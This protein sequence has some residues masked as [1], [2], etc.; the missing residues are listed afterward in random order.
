[1]VDLEL[2]SKRIVHQMS[3]EL[4]KTDVNDDFHTVLL[5]LDMPNSDRKAGFNGYLK[6]QNEIKES[7]KNYIN[8][9]EKSEILK[10]LSRQELKCVNQMLKSRSSRSTDRDSGQGSSKDRNKSENGELSGEKVIAKK[11]QIVVEDVEEEDIPSAPVPFGIPPLQ[12]DQLYE[13]MD[14]TD[15]LEWVSSQPGRSSSRIPEIPMEPVPKLLSHRH[16]EPQKNVTF[17]VESPP[18]KI[19]SRARRIQK[20]DAQIQT[21]EVEG[22]EKEEEEKIQTAEMG[23]NCRILITPRVEEVEEL[24]SQKS[25][26]LSPMSTVPSELSEGEVVGGSS[27][28]RVIVVR[29]DGSLVPTPRAIEDVEDDDDVVGY[30]GD[31]DVASDI[32]IARSTSSFG[33]AEV[34]MSI[35]SAHSH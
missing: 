25:P 3:R 29:T 32:L 1:M 19:L 16:P 26:L 33:V 6:L 30:D 31:Y 35:S 4:E 12:V 21:D 2:K 23:T 11:V 15:D 18:K 14:E 5:T 27:M 8:F 17:A 10:L 20:N 22:K 7:L 28:G 34:D 9:G 24:I 13:N